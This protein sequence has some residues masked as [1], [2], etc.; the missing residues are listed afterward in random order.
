[1]AGGTGNPYFTTDTAAVLR[2]TELKAD[3]VIKATKVDGVYD[4]DPVI[5]SDAKLIKNIGY[6]EIITKNIKVID[7]TAVTLANESK[8]PI[9]VTSLKNENGLINALNGIGNY[10]IIS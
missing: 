7:A 9:I 2:A 6:K 3:V 4:K 10:S 8:I 5:F 1:M